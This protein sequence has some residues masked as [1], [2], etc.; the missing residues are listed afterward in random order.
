MDRAPRTDRTLHDWWYGLGGATQYIDAL[1]DPAK[2]RPDQEVR[3]LASKC[4]AC[5]SL[6]DGVFMGIRGF[7]C[8][9]PVIDNLDADPP[10]C[11]CLVLG[12]SP[13]EAPAELTI[14]GT[15]MGAGKLVVK[16]TE[17]PQKRW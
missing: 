13:E 12:L 5:P 1:R 7:Y 10:T 14:A 16:G 6:H 15:V 11:G 3:E 9:P 17:C 8:G 2:R 4:A